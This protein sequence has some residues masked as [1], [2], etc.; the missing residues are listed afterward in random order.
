M[1]LTAILAGLIA[2]TALS[3]G[4]AR[5][6]VKVLSAAAAG[7]GLEKAAALYRTRSGQAVSIAYATGPEIQ[8]RIGGG[9][10]AFDV[11]VA[12]DAV[13]KALATRLPGAPVRLG[14]VGIGLAVKPGAP[15][16]DLSSVEALKAALLSAK[17]VVISKGST[18]VYLE[19]LFERLGLTAALAGKL[20]RAQNGA[21]VVTRILDG[22]GAEVGLAA[23][24]ELAGGLSRGLAIVGPLPA[25]MQN[26]TVYSA[27]A[28][29]TARPDVA[30]L[31]SL[32]ASREARPL[33]IA[34]GI[35]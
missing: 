23:Q 30:G 15:R 21:G 4:A 28:F 9:E 8:Q 14:A 1:R 24:T 10:T 22:S 13:L 7:P 31:M 27:A 3:T 5:A 33:M 17:T 2:A 26:A 35:D 6:E 20:E 32:L 18:G 12:P 19:G 25:P 34:S 16:P 11:I 29:P